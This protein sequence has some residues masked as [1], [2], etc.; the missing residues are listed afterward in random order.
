M[1]VLSVLTYSAET[2]TLT[3]AS[4]RK[5]Q[6]TQRRMERSMLEI[7]LR[8][9]FRNEEIRKRTVDDVLERITRA[10]WR[11]AGHIAR[12][13]DGRW[14]RRI[15]EWQPRADKRGPGRPPDGPMT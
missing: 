6:K 13:N 14:T 7:S 12:S 5:L 4:S 1:C 9:R 10:N 15:L 2:L 11:W 3:K 8:G